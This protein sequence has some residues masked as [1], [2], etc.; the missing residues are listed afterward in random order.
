MVIDRTTDVLDLDHR[1]VM[2]EIDPPFLG[3]LV[4]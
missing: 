2:Q 3:A 1:L 4:G